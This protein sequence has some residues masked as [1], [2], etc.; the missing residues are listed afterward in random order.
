VHHKGTITS[1]NIA[2]LPFHL[3][4]SCSGTGGD[5][6]TDEAA[7]GFFQEHLNRLGPADTSELADETVKKG[8]S[9]KSTPPQPKP[10][11]APEPEEPPKAKSPFKR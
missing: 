9:M 5:F 7:V 11:P 3:A 8:A 4:C 10:E 2:G 6:A 1:S